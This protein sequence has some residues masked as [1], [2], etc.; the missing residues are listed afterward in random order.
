MKFVKFMAGPWGR[1]IRMVAG[2]LIVLWGFGF[3]SDVLSII[4]MALGALVF[5]AGLYNF[6]LLAPIF[7]APLKAKDL[8]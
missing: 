8:D 5:S 4:T 7:R 2:L 3:I 6:C 1:G